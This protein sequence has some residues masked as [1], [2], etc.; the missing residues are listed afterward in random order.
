MTFS[1]AHLSDPHLCLPPGGPALRSLTPKQ[2]LA[3]ASWQRKRRHLTSPAVL[4]ALG[5]DVAAHAPDHI[6]VTGDLVN[7]AWRPEFS[8]ARTWLAALGPPGR[9]SVVP[10]N[11]DLT[12]AVPF[13]DGI[14]R[15]GAWMTGDR[16]PAPASAADFPFVRRRDDVAIIGLS[17]AVP[18]RVFSAAGYLGAAQ[19]DQAARLLDGA[20]RDGLFRIVLIHH[21]PMPVT[22]GRRKAL[23]DH[24]ALC[25]MLGLCG[26]ELVLHGHHHE[27]LLAALPG[28]AGPIPV[29]GAASASSAAPRPETAGWRHFTIGREHGFWRLKA[30]TRRYDPA[31][32]GFVQAGEWNLRLAMDNRSRATPV[33]TAT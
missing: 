5:Q 26:A 6:A 20:G 15:W 29:A 3:F 16:G 13:A 32:G 8:H 14:G 1:L 7:L 31:S 33:N 10:G 23:R 22:G 27:S 18:T 24:A 28:P 21:P 30:V 17:S 9:V 12:R 2:L 19:L 11:H 4:D 25:T